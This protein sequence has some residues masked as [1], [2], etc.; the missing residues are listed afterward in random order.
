V[1]LPRSVR[2]AS[3]KRRFLSSEAAEAT[4]FTTK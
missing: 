4:S 1:D 2:Q 3:W